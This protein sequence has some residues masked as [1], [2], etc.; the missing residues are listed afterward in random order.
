[1]MDVTDL[2]WNCMQLYQAQFGSEC[3]REAVRG[4]F[5]WA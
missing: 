5:G 4:W 3:T 1:M 2:R